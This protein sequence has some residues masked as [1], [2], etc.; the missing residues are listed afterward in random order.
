MKYS[1]EKEEWEWEVR[2]GGPSH[3]QG[4]INQERGFTLRGKLNLEN[5]LGYNRR[6]FDK[7]VRLGYFVW[8]AERK[9][10]N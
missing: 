6:V 1:P 10:R 4:R 9:L 2:I 8:V 7:L 3:T 5:R